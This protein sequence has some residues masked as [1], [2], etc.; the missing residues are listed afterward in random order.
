M[1]G[2]KLVQKGQI[3]SIC[4][5]CRYYIQKPGYW[6]MPQDE[7]LT[8]GSSKIGWLSGW[9]IFKICKP[10]CL[11]RWHTN[12]KGKERVGKNCT[13]TRFVMLRFLIWCVN[14]RSPSII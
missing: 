14:E 6:H 13:E 8:G 3:H 5:Y 9:M 1:E 4:H 11:Q 2:V 10:V 7:G 12:V